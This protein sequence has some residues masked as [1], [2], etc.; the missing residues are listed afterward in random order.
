MLRF[1]VKN[2]SVKMSV[3]NNSIGMTVA[4][5]VKMSVCGNNIGMTVEKAAIVGGISYEGS[6]EITP[7]LEGMTLKTAQTFL[8][9]DIKIKKIPITTVS[10]S[11]GGNTVIIGG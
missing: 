2:G 10:N 8:E 6:Y 5:S 7:T 3:G 1:K 9:K 4:E 11:S